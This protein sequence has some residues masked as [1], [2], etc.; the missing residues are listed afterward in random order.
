MKLKYDDTAEQLYYFTREAKKAAAGAYFLGQVLGDMAGRG[1]TL[2]EYQLQG[3]AGLVR[4]LGGII[5]SAELECREYI[6]DVK[7]II[8]H[9][10]EC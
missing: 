8:D 2:D 10:R 5:D 9:E 1:E 4:G 6:A 3:V 7:R